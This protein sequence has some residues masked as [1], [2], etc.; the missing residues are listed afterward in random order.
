MNRRLVDILDVKDNVWHDRSVDLREALGDD[1]EENYAMLAAEIDRRGFAMWG[2]GASPL[3][4][5]LPASDAALLNAANNDDLDGAIKPIMDARGIE[6]GDVAGACFSDF[7]WQVANKAER[8]EALR[9][10]LQ[11]EDA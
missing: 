2:G 8:I 7:D 1:A 4:E 6:A 10:W 5:I 9:R 11:A 3:Y